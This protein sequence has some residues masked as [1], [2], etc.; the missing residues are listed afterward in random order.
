MIMAVTPLCENCIY[1]Y[2]TTH[3]YYC[4]CEIIVIENGQCKAFKEVIHNANKTT[5][6]G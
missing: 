1:W 2:K 6:T 5:G 4:R 3:Y